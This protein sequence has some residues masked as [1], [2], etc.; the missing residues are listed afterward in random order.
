MIQTSITRAD[1][2]DW[3]R[4]A[5]E[6]IQ[7]SKCGYHFGHYI[8]AAE[9][10]YLTALHTARINL[11]LET[12]IPY[13]RWGHGLTCLLEKEFGSIYVDKLR[14][15]CL[16]EADFNWLQKIIFS[17]RMI[18]AAH[19]KGVIPPEQCAT[20]NVDSNQGNMMKVCLLYTSPSP[21]D[22]RGSRMPSSA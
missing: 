19:A 20:T 13:E 21:R 8:A 9:N 14:A 2:Q 12:G 17:H 4:T 18:K 6:A 7:S 5:K 16:F 3:W 15:I 22:Q 11:A 10:D 1:F